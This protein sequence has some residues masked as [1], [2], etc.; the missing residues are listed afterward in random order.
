MR[1][2]TNII[3]G[4]PERLGDTLFRTPV[5][6][7][8]KAIFPHVNID[9]IAPTNLSFEVLNYNPYIRELFIQ[10]GIEQI[11]NLKCNYD[12]VID[13]S[14][15][16]YMENLVKGFNGEHI[17]Y[18]DDSG[19]NMHSAEKLLQFFAK[20][21]QYDLNNFTRQYDIYP[22]QENFTHIEKLLSLKNIDVNNEILIGFHM[23]CFSLVKRRTRLW[24][25]FSHPRVWLLKNFI[26]LTEKLRKYNSLIR[27]VLTGSGEETKLGTIFCKKFPNSINLI[28]RTSVLDLAALM[29]Y[30]QLFVGNDTGSM[31]VACTSNVSIIALFGANNP[32]INMP[33]PMSTN[34]TVLFKPKI[35]DITV[36]GVFQA[37][38]RCINI[39]K[40]K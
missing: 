21:F 28:N 4:M 30:L 20:L 18:L 8:L 25:K 15:S 27:I 2:I 6:R 13:V 14:D 3:V 23:G 24:N 17:N 26:E 33:Y 22:Q 35:A 31:H 34:R 16:E 9:V 39:R 29:S 38:C 40:T 11:K 37:I 19:L 7:L 36:D 12:L 1:S 5:L 10:P 32:I